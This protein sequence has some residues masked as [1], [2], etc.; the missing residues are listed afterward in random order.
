MQ[1]RSDRTLHRLLLAALTITWSG[2]DRSPT[3]PVPDAIVV[4]LTADTL[5]VGQSRQ[6][7][8]SYVLSGTQSPSSRSLRW[9]SSDTAILV[10][11][12]LTGLMSARS[13]GLGLRGEP[14]AT[15]TAQ[16]RGV[17]AKI[18]V[19]VIPTVGR[20]SLLMSSSV[21][22]GRTVRPNVAAY[23]G[24]RFYYPLP[25][26]GPARFASS[27]AGVLRV[28]ADGSLTALSLGTAMVTMSL[29]AKR[30]S[31]VVNVV[32]GFEI[33]LLGGTDSMAIRGVNDAG[34]VAG[35]VAAAVR[36]NVLVSTSQR[37]DLSACSPAAIN[38]AGQVACN[39]PTGYP[40]VHL[41]GSMT[42]PMGSSAGSPTGLVTGLTENGSLYGRISGGSD[43]TLRGRVFLAGSTGV[44]FRSAQNSAGIM[45]TGG[46]NSSGYGTALG[47][48]GACTYCPSFVIG[49]D[50]RLG[51][52]SINGRYSEPRDINDSK[53]VVGRSENFSG[54]G[55]ATIFREV[56]QY[57]GELLAPRTT[58]A[59][60]ISEG[61]RVVGDG[62]DGGFVWHAGRYT[63][64]S[65]A[66]A[67]QGWTIT[68]APAIS[69]SGLI[70]ARGEHASRG[71][72]IVL[73]R[74]P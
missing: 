24:S 38:N 18:E 67:E 4:S 48:G 3:E 9:L 62:A 31:L 44:N 66:V 51:M 65:D 12:S 47:D 16:A 26:A 2:C 1:L 33:T 73:I 74:I 50:V 8:A 45:T 23:N 25:Q 52:R 70:A 30:D 53:D 21:A 61:D 54:A 72:G 46:V 42:Y 34:V 69:R 63:I 17:E 32:P 57:M 60:A 14:L 6:L 15:V 37:T 5:E 41:N 59:W 49:A 13:T 68:S 56:N 20:A 71:R 35:S 36:Q 29:R 58:T 64:L 19:L 10:V 43:T 7:T 11:D 28:N 55:N 39:N 27:D 40:S 22:V